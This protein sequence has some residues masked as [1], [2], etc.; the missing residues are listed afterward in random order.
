[1]TD[2]LKR[3][4]LNV[5]SLGQNAFKLYEKMYH[6]HALS[7]KAPISQ[8]FIIFKVLF[9]RHILGLFQEGSYL[10]CGK[11]LSPIHLC[12]HTRRC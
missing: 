3:L 10:S 2:A 12:L 7:P 1:M 9:L 5:I 8:T 11:K 6:F 4:E